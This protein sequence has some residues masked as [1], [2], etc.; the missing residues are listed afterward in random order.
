MKN[1]EKLSISSNK[2]GKVLLYFAL[3]CVFTLILSS[4]YNTVDQIYIG[5]SS[6]G[7][8]GNSAVGVFFPAILICQAL[9]WYI[10]DGSA[11]YINLKQGKKETEGLDKTIGTGMLTLFVLSL[12]MMVI[13]MIFSRPILFFFGATAQSIDYAT[14]YL[15]I[16]SIAFPFFM[17]QNMLCSV[18]RADGSPIYALISTGCGTLLNVGLTPLFL[19]AFDMGMKGVALATTLSMIISFIISFLYIFRSKSFH[20]KLSSFKPSFTAL[21]PVLRLG[22]TSLFTQLS[23]LAFSI[24]TN[25]MILIYGPLSKYGV[26]IPIALVA[27]ENKAFSI[28]INIAM[29]IA[30]GAQPIISYNI[31][32]NN[33]KN[34][35]KA[36]FFAIL[37]TSI[38]ALLMTV[39]VLINPDI[40]MNIFGR[41]TDPLYNEFGRKVF[42]LFMCTMMLTCFTKVSSVFLQSCGKPI[43]ALIAAF[44]KDIPFMIMMVVVPSI[45]EKI[46]PGLGMDSVL[47]TSLIAD[48]LGVAVSTIF[49][50][51]TFHKMENKLE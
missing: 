15:M 7:Y 1:V 5:N 41:S 12:L 13:F 19:F 44:S 3:P 26:D 25:R 9:A 45:V 42:R 38:I 47:Y 11:A 16:L 20:L 34:V 35:K 10:G 37:S 27:N 40:L 6:I 50:I 14:D 39:I 32:A 18:I 22:L 49:D 46:N 31:G 43:I 36:F 30:L 33:T 23:V 2:V 4:L 8:I 51:K 28:V 24:V 21:K 17:I 29:G 48:V